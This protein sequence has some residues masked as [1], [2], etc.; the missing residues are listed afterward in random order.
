MAGKQR[1]QGGRTLSWA[2]RRVLKG[3]DPHGDCSESGR[4]GRFY[5]REKMQQ[6]ALPNA[7][8]RI[9]PKLGLFGLTCLIAIVIRCANRARCRLCRYSENGILRQH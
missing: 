6:H 5:T 3:I 8:W 4:L 2:K 9:K 7:A 1:N